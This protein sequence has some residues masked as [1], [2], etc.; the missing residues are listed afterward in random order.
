MRQ[1]RGS[2]HRSPN[3]SGFLWA[4][5]GHKYHKNH[6]HQGC[7]GLSAGVAVFNGALRAFRARSSGACMRIYANTSAASAG[8]AGSQGGDGKGEPPA[9]RAAL[10]AASPRPRCGSGAVAQ[11]AWLFEAGA[12]EKGADAAALCQLRKGAAAAAAAL[13]HALH[14]PLPPEAEEDLYSE[15]SDQSDLE[16]ASL[17][18]SWPSED[19]GAPSSVRGSS[20]SQPLAKRQRLSVAV[21]LA[22]YPPV[23]A[24]THSLGGQLLSG[25]A[26]A[27]GPGMLAWR[28]L[29]PAAQRHISS[30]G[31]GGGGDEAH[32][33]E[34]RLAKIRAR[35]AGSHWRWG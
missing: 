14:V 22:V 18:P 13:S 17:E 28:Q 8:S 6:L 33:R 27:D 31:A 23:P 9:A 19:A 26:A 35:Q 7:P 30:S 34:A 3:L 11:L 4:S 20:G 29:R 2:G 10:Q 15:D 21:P 32:A 24:A 1:L 5:I 16:A 12:G 25:S